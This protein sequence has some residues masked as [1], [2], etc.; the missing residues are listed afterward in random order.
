MSEA[1][2]DAIVVG[3]G[4]VGAAVAYGLACHALRV[5]I[6][7]EDDTAW[8]ASRGNFALV[9]VQSKGLGMPRYAAWTKL[10][11]DI[12]ADFAAELRDASGID[13]AHSR[14]GG[15][16]LALSEQELEQRRQTLHRLHNQPDMVP[17]PYEFVDRA[18]LRQ[19]FPQIGPEV[20][21]ASFCPLDG[22]V[23]S[24]RLFRALHTAFARLG[25]RYLPRHRVDDIAH[26]DGEFRV[27]AAG[28]S[29]A[30]ARVVLAAGN[31]NRRLAPMVGLEAPVRPQRG[32]V[33]V[34]ER[35]A[36]FLTHPIVT[37]RQTD[38]GGIM[39]GDSLEEAGF[40]TRLGLGVLG[41]MASRAVRMFPVLGRLNVVRSWAALRVMTPD[42]FPIYDQSADA[43]GAFLCTCHSGVTL[44]AVH[45]GKVA[46]M[47]AAGVLS[48]DL[49]PFSAYRFGVPAAA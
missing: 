21:G 32:Q 2:F 11:S 3:G 31:G 46:P 47:I 8:R 13:V 5:A 16:T 48:P 42:G 34:T 41:T 30:A 29:F 24:L 15:F 37:L 27:T 22:H 18:Q 23:N 1:E 36:P 4:L 6:L 44:A 9:W 40:D 19:V 45:A 49:A 28:R 12:W 17:Y 7:D 14:P 35:A 26:R 43:P 38:E 39:I 10:S 20:V 33:I 25:G